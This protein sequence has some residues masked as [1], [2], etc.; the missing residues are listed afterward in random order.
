MSVVTLQLGQCGNQIGQLFFDTLIK[1]NHPKTKGKIT[2]QYLGQSF[3]RFFTQRDNGCYEARAVSVDTEKKVVSKVLNK[4]E[5]TGKWCYPEG[6]QLSGRRGAGNNWADGFYNH[7]TKCEEEVLDLVQK[8]LEKCDHFGGFL[9]LM[10]IGGGTGSGLGTHITQAL[11]DNFDQSFLVNVLIWPHN[12]GEVIVQNYNAVLSLAHLS[13]S[14]DALLIFQNDSIKK[15]VQKMSPA[16][17]VTFFDM[18]KIVTD[19]LASTLQ[20]AVS[21]FGSRN[22]LGSYLEYLVPHPDYKLLTTRFAPQ[23]TEGAIP[24]STFKWSSLTKTTNQMLITQDITE[25]GLNWH[26]KSSSTRNKTLANLLIMRGKDSKDVNTN[27]FT[28]PELYPSWIQGGAGLTTYRQEQPFQDYE[29]TLALLSNDQTPIPALDNMV[30]K[31]WDMFAMRAYTH[32]YT[33][34]GMAE[35]EFIDCFA[36]LE[37]MISNYRML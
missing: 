6:Q 4:A 8:E 28:A 16:S 34:Y 21:E 24:F 3:Q 23:V 31:A 36:K 26:V 25:E 17:K 19:H 5:K 30:Q 9:S 2:Q 35:E 10:S 29:K 32:W 13:E 18:N 15:I 11:K 27:A 12:T 20:P 37:Q 14:A 1:D 22:L 7:G 33:H